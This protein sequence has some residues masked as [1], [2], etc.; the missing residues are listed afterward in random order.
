MS[1]LLDSLFNAVAYGHF[2]VDVLNGQRSVL[3]TYWSQELG[4]SNSWL[5]MVSTI[6]V[7]VASLSQPVFGWI[8][9]RFGKTRLMAA[10]GIL[11]L[12]GFFALALFLPLNWAIPCLI[13]GSLGS[14]SFHP[15][16]ATQA[17]LRGRTL[18]A[19][20]E[21]TSTSWFFLFGQFGYFMGP[22]LGGPLLQHFGPGGLLLLAVPALAIGLNAAWRLRTPV[23]AAEAGADPAPAARLAQSGAA[24]QRSRTAALARGKA[25]F[26][27]ALIVVA[28]LQSWAQQNMNTFLPKYLSDLGQTPTVYGLL[29]GL[30]MGGSALGNVLGGAL[31]DRFGHR[32]VAVF[33]LALASL[34]LIAIAQVGWTGWLYL[35]V[36]L[37]GACTGA[38]HSIIVVLA[39]RLL[40]GGMALASGLTLGFMFSAGALGTLLSGPLADQWGF[41]PVFLMT[42]GLAGIASLAALG[43]R[44]NQVTAENA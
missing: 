14:A 21:T 44:E 9:D 41:A 37:A 2:I 4:L 28:G 26:V 24:G 1:L 3:L 25:G 27:A 23:Q 5:A 40:K 39:Q 31:A 12:T 16:G 15:S 34:P 13:L 10:G 7:W 38:V 43:L 8:T 33:M 32:R 29:T 17:T 36:P 6:Y 30:F 18:L 35:L 20:R 11:W 42:A 22:I 19:G